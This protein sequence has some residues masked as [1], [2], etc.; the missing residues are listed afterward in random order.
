MKD[1]FFGSKLNSILLLVIIVL[2]IIAIFIFKNNSNQQISDENYENQMKWATENNG[3]PNG[4][5][6]W[7][8]TIAEIPVEKYGPSQ[9]G[10]SY[11]VLLTTELMGGLKEK[12]VCVGDSDSALCAIGSDSEVLRYFDIINYRN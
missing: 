4:W 8:D 9:N 1:K 10:S 2:M 6:K 3:I 5:V 7:S 12:K 11:I